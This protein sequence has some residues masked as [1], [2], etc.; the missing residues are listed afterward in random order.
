MRDDWESSQVALLR[1]DTRHEGPDATI[2]VEGE[3]DH[4]TAEQ[5]RTCILEVLDT[6]PRSVTVDARAVTF[7]DS[8]GLSALLRAH[9]LAF[10]DRVDFR[11][12][13]P[14]PRLRRLVEETGTKALLLPDE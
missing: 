4:S 12:S 13:D 8:T 10:V 9:G 11:I 7:T 1:V 14:S 5:F 6:K 3:L 2:T